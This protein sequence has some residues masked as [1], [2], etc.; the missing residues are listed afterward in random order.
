MR[1]DNG[2]PS[3]WWT[4]PLA[5]WHEKMTFVAEHNEAVPGVG[6][7]FEIQRSAEAEGGSTVVKIGYRRDDEPLNLPQPGTWVRL[8][9][10]SRP[11]M[12]I[13]APEPPC[14]SPKGH[15]YFRGPGDTEHRC[16]RCGEPE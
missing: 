7:L 11:P 16:T 14:V 12:Q 1:E 6:V 5:T 4:R 9:P 8:Y 13:P 3:H 2:Q 15:S 10:T